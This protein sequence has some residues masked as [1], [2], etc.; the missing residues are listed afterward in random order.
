MEP[1]KKIKAS[2][3][4]EDNN[5]DRTMKPIKKIDDEDDNTDEETND[6]TSNTPTKMEKAKKRRYKK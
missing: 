6:P 5:E 1:V 4:D 2:Q 3:D